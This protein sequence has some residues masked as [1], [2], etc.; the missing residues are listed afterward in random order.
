MQ[1]TIY[2]TEQALEVANVI[3]DLS[4]SERLALSDDPAASLSAS[5]GY[6]LKNANRLNLAALP[7]DALVGCRLTPDLPEVYERHVSIPSNLRGCIFENAPKLPDQY[8]T[9][10]AYWSGPPVNS[11]IS[12][13]CYFQSPEHSYMVDMSALEA[14]NADDGD[15]AHASA[16]IDDLLSEGVVVCITDIEPLIDD[17]SIH[18][19]IEISL[20]VDGMLGIEPED[21]CSTKPYPTGPSR[22]YERVYLK[23][24]DILRSPDRNRIYIDLLRHE[25]L[26]YGY[27]Y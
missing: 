27:W 7:P 2:V 16:L 3:K 8:A 24:A 13:A 15:E 14:V 17:L 26:D 9:I 4:Q 19:Y 1:A 11:N 5:E 10:V 18:D 21:F 12:G 20:P 22:Q 25:L 6:Y 23:V